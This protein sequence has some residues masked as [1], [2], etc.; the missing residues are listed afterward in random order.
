MV[1]VHRWSLITGSFVH[2]MRNWGIK[3]VVALDRELLNIDIFLATGLTVYTTNKDD[4]KP[5]LGTSF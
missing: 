5:C 4:E 3:S 1:V 2:K